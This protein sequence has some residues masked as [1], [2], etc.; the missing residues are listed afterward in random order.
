MQVNVTV[1]INGPC[2][3]E[4]SVAIGPDAARVEINGAA[5]LAVSIADLREFVAA[6]ERV[7]NG[8]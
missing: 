8:D 2:G 4:L 7:T 5:S 6:I 1:S 3:Q